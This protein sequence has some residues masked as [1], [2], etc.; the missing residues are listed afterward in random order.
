MRQLESEHVNQQGNVHLF[1]HFGSL[2]LP[3]SKVAMACPQCHYRTRKW[4]CNSLVVLRYF[5]RCCWTM[6]SETSP[7]THGHHNTATEKNHNQVL[8]NK[9]V[10]WWG[11]GGGSLQSVESVDS[12]LFAWNLQQVRGSPECSQC[13][14]WIFH[15]GALT[16]SEASN[17][18]VH[19][20]III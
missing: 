5:C 16:L 3:V 2:C 6:G 8:L 7:H 1:N 18:E 20:K 13:S 19:I 17:W 11:G 10:F 4:S 9:K 12:P 14:S 15:L